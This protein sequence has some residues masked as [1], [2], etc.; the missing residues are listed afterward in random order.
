MTILLSL[1][2]EGSNDVLTCKIFVREDDDVD[3]V[4][5]TSLTKLFR[6]TWVLAPGDMIKITKV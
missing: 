3:D 6:H 5:C 2:S 4:I 1:L